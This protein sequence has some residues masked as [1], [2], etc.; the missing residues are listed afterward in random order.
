MLYSILITGTL[1]ET[2][3]PGVFIVISILSGV[4]LLCL[5]YS[6]A[7][8]GYSSTSLLLLAYAPS[9]AIC[10]AYSNILIIIS[11]SGVLWHSKWYIL[12]LSSVR[13]I[14]L[15]VTFFFNFPSVNFIKCSFCRSVISSF[16][17]YCSPNT[18]LISGINRNG[19][20]VV[21]VLNTS[22]YGVPVSGISFI[23]SIITI[24]I[25]KNNNQLRLFYTYDILRL[26]RCKVLFMTK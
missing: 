4:L 3:P 7:E 24:L 1:Y 12:P 8:C 17:V 15:S 2:S 23:L 9:S 16:P 20:S 5:K 13:L 19:Q 22:S 26:F 6:I 11:P 10:E 25:I 21:I 18:S 14:L